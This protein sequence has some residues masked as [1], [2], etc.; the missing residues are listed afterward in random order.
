M[1]KLNNNNKM[2]NKGVN[3]F[4]NRARIYLVGNIT[5][6][7]K[8]Y[9]KALRTRAMNVKIIKTIKI[10]MEITALI[11][12]IITGLILMISLLKIVIQRTLIELKGVIS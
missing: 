8:W 7:M 9:I 5:I 1:I 11:T 10:T 12:L 3:V 6:K 4:L 2:I